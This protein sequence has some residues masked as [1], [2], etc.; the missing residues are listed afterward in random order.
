MPRGD[1]RMSKNVRETAA[2]L[3]YG[4]RVDSANL[5]GTEQRLLATLAAD[6]L[7]AYPDDLLEV[8]LFGSRARG[9]F[10]EDSDLDVAVI[11]GQ[12]NHSRNAEIF[13]KARSLGD[14]VGYRH[15]I[16]T[17]P[18]C[19]EEFRYCQA[20][21]SHYY[22]T[23]R[24]DGIVIWRRPGAGIWD[25]TGV[26]PVGRER[27][28]ETEL[29][30][31]QA[32]LH[33]VAILLDADETDGAARSAYY[34]AFHAV[35]AIL[36]TANLEAKTHDGTNALFGQHFAATGIVPKEYGPWLSNLEELRKH[37]DYPDNW[38]YEP[39]DPDQVRAGCQKAEEMVDVL[40]RYCREW[41][42]RQ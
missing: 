23:M 15:F 3:E 12:T 8:R 34:A 13:E 40:E 31:A 7:S 42:D 38:S 19:L 4:L 32:E 28:V 16:N 36:L 11:L 26:V 10:R 17:H 41:L 1:S 24:D 2:A 5:T 6:L 14:E 35:K 25:E 9:D 18:H 33:M 29:K 37:A 30:K 22:R 21:G 20:T 39:L 27:D